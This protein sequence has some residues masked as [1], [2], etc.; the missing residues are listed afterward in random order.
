[1]RLRLG[2]RDPS[3]AGLPPSA[4]SCVPAVAWAGQ[5]GGADQAACPGGGPRC[6]LR[7]ALWVSG[8]VL[9]QGHKSGLGLLQLRGS[10]GPGRSGPGNMV[11]GVG[12]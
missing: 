10:A 5:A 2:G 3:A 4:P 12:T 6:L 9:S 7:Y 1:M 8:A 11:G